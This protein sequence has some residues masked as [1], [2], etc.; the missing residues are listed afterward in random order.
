MTPA[1]S[2]D[3][4]DGN[5]EL[6]TDKNRPDKPRSGRSRDVH[7]DRTKKITHHLPQPTDAQGEDELRAKVSTLLDY[8]AIN[9]GATDW[10][11]QK[12]LHLDRIMEHFQ[13]ELTQQ[14]DTMLNGLEA[15]VEKEIKRDKN[16]TTAYVEHFINAKR[17][18]G[19]K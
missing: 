17:E 11:L 10:R 15:C 5:F 7:R 3:Q 1:N 6:F 16:S 12:V 4:R 19:G 8:Y 9:I 14:Q 2:P 13:A 18:K